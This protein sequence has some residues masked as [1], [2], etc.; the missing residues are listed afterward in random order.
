M[1]EDRI[2]TEAIAEM[3]DS[4]RLSEMLELGDLKDHSGWKYLRER[5]GGIREK[6]TL[7]LAR[8]LMAG[9]EISKEEIAFHRGYA[10]GVTDALNYPERLER[11]FERAAEKA[12][13]RAQE[14]LSEED[15]EE[16]YI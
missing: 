16:P 15:G 14:R 10:N 3:K 12:W 13:I 7:A 1:E 2:L 9:A 4:P 11:E 6:A 5:M 8:R